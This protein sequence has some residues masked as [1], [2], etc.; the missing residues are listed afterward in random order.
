MGALVPLKEAVGE[1]KFWPLIV[2]S[3]LAG[4]PMGD[5]EVIMGAPRGSV[6][7]VAVLDGDEVPNGFTAST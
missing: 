5:V 6:V 3:A 7:A 2:I 1:L 4:A